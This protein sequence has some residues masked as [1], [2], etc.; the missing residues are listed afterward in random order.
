MSQVKA[1]PLQLEQLQATGGTSSN[2]LAIVRGTR[3]LDTVYHHCFLFAL[4]IS[5]PLFFFPPS[6]C[7]RIPVPEVIQNKPAS[8][9]HGEQDEALRQHA[10]RPL[11]SRRSNAVRPRAKPSASHA[12]DEFPM[13]KPSLL[14]AASRSEPSCCTAS[15]SYHRELLEFFSERAII[16]LPRCVMSLAHLEWWTAMAA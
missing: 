10:G 13:A 1:L 15:S 9:V 14:I 5:H 7:S 16:R 12:L 3:I 2:K 4:C 11:R 6:L 8:Q